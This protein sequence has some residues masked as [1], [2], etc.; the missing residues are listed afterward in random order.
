MKTYEAD[1][2][3]ENPVSDL[4]QARTYLTV[5]NMTTFLLERDFVKDS[6]Y[7]NDILHIEW[8]LQDEQSGV[9]RLN[10]KCELPESLLKKISEWIR[11]Q[12]S[13]GLG[14][15]FEQQDFASYPQYDAYEDEDDYQEYD[16]ICA[17]FDWSSNDY[18]LKLVKEW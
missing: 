18:P 7:A 8:D 2:K 14:E 11:G 1:F 15:G 16:Y 9:I 13:D 10:T 12:N 4:G 6:G 3:L 5:D 17:S